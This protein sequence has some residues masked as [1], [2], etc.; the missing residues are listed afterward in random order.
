MKWKPRQ[1]F[2]YTII[3]AFNQALICM[4]SG[5]S[6]LISSSVYGVKSPRNKQSCQKIEN[7]S[8]F[9]SLSSVHGP[10]LYNLG[11]PKCATDCATFTH[12]VHWSKYFAKSWFDEFRCVNCT[13]NNC[14][15]QKKKLGLK[16]IRQIIE[17]K[18]E[19]FVK[20]HWRCRFCH[21]QTKFL[22]RFWLK[23]DSKQ[24]TSLLSVHPVEDFE[25]L[26]IGIYILTV[27]S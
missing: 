3:I 4:I 25:K 9:G 22:S 21:C 11:G 10:S 7:I 20:R 24:E 5:W 8:L 6:K 18:K 26:F 15:R 13:V 27:S 17:V 16:K 12:V 2:E 19:N 1:I 14:K 23:M